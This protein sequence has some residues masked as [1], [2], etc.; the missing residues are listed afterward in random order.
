MKDNY[1]LQRGS[2]VG[3]T[4]NL[5]SVL[6]SFVLKEKEA[7]FEFFVFCSKGKLFNL[8]TVNCDIAFVSFPQNRIKLI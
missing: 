2:G 4:L 7:F 1:A 5:G 8:F 3:G 6:S